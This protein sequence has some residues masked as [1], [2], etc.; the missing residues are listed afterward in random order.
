MTYIC[1]QFSHRMELNFTVAIDF[2]ASNG[3]PNQS[4]SLHYTTP[5]QPSLYARALQA[6]GGIIQD[7]D[8]LA[9]L[10]NIYYFC[11]FFQYTFQLC[12]TCRQTYSLI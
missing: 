6:V 10:L 4:T 12:C 9:L 7:Y 1:C 2:T 3:D 11:V 5:Y 8:T